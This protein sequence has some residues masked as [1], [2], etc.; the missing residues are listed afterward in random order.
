MVRW[1]Y[2]ARLAVA[3]AIFLAA[4]YRWDRA[5]AGDTLLAS[6]VCVAALLV[7]AGQAVY[8]EVWARPLPRGFLYGHA[9]FDL[10][11]VTAVVH[12]TGGLQSQFAALYIL[13]IGSAALLLPG[14]GGLLVAALGV[15]LYLA[16]AVFG[17]HEA[18]FDAA[19]WLQLAV[20]AAVAACGAVITARLHDMGAVREELAAELVQ[21]RLQASDI[22]HNIRSGII[23]VNAH[24]RLLYA[25][26]AAGTLLGL[27]LARST[28]RLVLPAI[29]T[30]AAELADALERGVLHGI[31]TTR[32]EGTITL[33]ERTFPVGVTTTLSEVEGRGTTVTA[34]F[35]DLSESKRLEALHLRAQRLEAV[36]TLSASLAHEIR[37]PLASIRS[38]VEQLAAMPQ[39]GD[40]ERTLGGLIVRESDRLSRLLTEFLDFARVRV[41]RVAP[42]DMA[43]VAEGATALAAAHPD[44]D[45]GIVVRWIPPA[46]PVVV[47]GDED[48]LHRAVFNLV[49]NAVQATPAP[50]E[51]RVE[52]A[53]VEQDSLPGGVV[54]DRGAVALRVSDTGPG[55]PPE[56]EE[57]LFEPFVTTKTG[58]TGLGLAVVHRAVEAHLGLVFVD[59]DHRGSRFTVLLPV[60]RGEGDGPL[61]ADDAVPQILAAR[62]SPAHAQEALA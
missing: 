42:V 16:D 35:Q 58:G 29:A 31:R 33:G 49:L 1:G 56:L 6:V 4:V 5:A 26:P 53:P 14:G 45:P 13:V 54:F 37:N 60:T 25:N 17:G 57:S 55:I 20:F 3:G 52:V 38:A 10:L 46:A 30:T 22:L 43:A 15:A 23:T 62:P 9:A 32:A 7:T 48:L 34:I 41:T 44:R 47:E 39:A 28:G 59:G 24:G 19:S 40:D 8:S 12:L 2:L 51:V 50:G 36:A 21:A 11:L 27:D 18:T 61:P